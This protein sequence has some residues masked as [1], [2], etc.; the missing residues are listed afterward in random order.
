M[1]PVGDW[2]PNGFICFW[3]SI[4]SLKFY[5]YDPTLL[6]TLGNKNRNKHKQVNKKKKKNG[7]IIVCLLTAI[8]W[9][10]VDIWLSFQSSVQLNLQGSE[11]LISI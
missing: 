8:G 4:D 2:N 5:W 9:C 1:P 10:Q 11:Q 3:N 7:N 6:W